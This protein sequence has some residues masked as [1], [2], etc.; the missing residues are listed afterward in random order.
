MAKME[1]YKPLAAILFYGP[2]CGAVHAFDPKENTAPEYVEFYDNLRLAYMRYQRN[3][4]DGR[5][6]FSGR[7]QSAP[8]KGRTP[9]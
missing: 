4:L 6:Y 8:P 7:M 1:F 2:H 9:S 3:T 5:Y